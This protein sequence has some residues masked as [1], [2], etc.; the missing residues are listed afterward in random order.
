MTVFQHM[1]WT[2]FTRDLEIPSS[3]SFND[4]EGAKTIYLDLLYTSVE[5]GHH[6]S[7]KGYPG[8]INED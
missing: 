2:G 7:G 4:Y 6:Q 1:N 3:K 5:N 8:L